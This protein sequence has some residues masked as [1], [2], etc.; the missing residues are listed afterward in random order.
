MEDYPPIF[1]L[2]KKR[3]A[4]VPGGKYARRFENNRCTFYDF[5]PFL[6]INEDTVRDAARR[7]GLAEYPTAPFRASITVAGG[8]K[9]YAEETWGEFRLSNGLRMIKIK[10]CPRCHVPCIDQKTG[11]WQ[12]KKRPFLFT[13]ALK[14]AFPDKAMDPEWENT[15]LIADKGSWANAVAFGV[16]FGHGGAKGR[17]SV[18][19]TIQVVERTSWNAHLG[20]AYYPLTRL[21]RWAEE[22]PLQAGLGLAVGVGL[23]AVAGGLLLRGRGSR[24]DWT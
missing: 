3:D 1:S 8:G 14:A 10:E 18:G 4:D 23:A 13:K 7:M 16:Y 12:L 6:L 2:I 21:W 15:E 22:E 11:G 19:D 20:P 5:A 24:G 9:A 17:I